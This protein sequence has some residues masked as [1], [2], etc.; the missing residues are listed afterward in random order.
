MTYEGKTAIGTSHPGIP[1]FMFAKTPHMTWAI[2]SSLTDLSDMFKENISDDKL[3]YF[4]DGDWKQMK[5]INEHIAIKGKKPMP[6]DIKYTHRGPI[7]DIPLLQGAVV[8]FS[9]GIPSSQHGS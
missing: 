3:Q 6:F 2:T 8:L 4:V 5:V 9:E 1:L 7:V